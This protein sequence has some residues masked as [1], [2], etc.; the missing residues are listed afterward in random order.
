LV[1]PGQKDTNV[2]VFEVAKK[3]FNI[4]K[5]EVAGKL[6]KELQNLETVDLLEDL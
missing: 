6:S 3:R 5:N 1:L 2:D 4:D